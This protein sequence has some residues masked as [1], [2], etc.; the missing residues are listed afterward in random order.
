MNQADCDYD[1]S[2]ATLRLKFYN[3]IDHLCR[4]FVDKRIVFLRLRSCPSKVKKPDACRHG[5][6]PIGSKQ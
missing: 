2:V 5:S 1:A 6:E 4:G 3:S